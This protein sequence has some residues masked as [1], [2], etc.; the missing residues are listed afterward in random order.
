MAASISY[1]IGGKFDSKPLDQAN[2]GIQKLTK[3][4]GAMKLAIG[5]FVIGTAL[6]GLKSVVDGSTEAFTNQ[7]KALTAANKAFA[8]NNKLS[9]ESVKNIKAAMD[10]FSLNNFIDG[11]TLNNAAALASNMGLNET[12]IIKT[13]DA[14]KEL[15]A[16]TGQDLN[17]CVKQLSASYSGN[18]SQLQKLNPELKNLTKEELANGKAIELIK[19]KYDGFSESMAN[20]FEGRATQFKNQFSD[21]QASIGGIGKALSFVGQGKMLEPLKEMTSYIEEHKNQIINFFLHLP[22]IAGV[23]FNAV[24]ESLSRLFT[25]DG[26]IDLG[27]YIVTSVQNWMPVLTEIWKAIGEVMFGVFDV[28]FGNLGRLFYNKVI[29]SIKEGLQNVINDFVKEHPNIAG[30]FNLD[31]IKLDLTPKVYSKLSTYTEKASDNIEKAKHNAEEANKKQ[32]AANLAFA[33]KYSD[34]TDKATGQI[35]NILNQELP[36]DLQ[37]AFAAGGDVI[38]NK[39]ASI[40]VGASGSV[41]TSKAESGVKRLTS[42]LNQLGGVFDITGRLIT[43]FSERASAIGKAKETFSQAMEGVVEG[44]AEAAMAQQG[45]AAATQA[46]SASFKSSIIGLIIEL[47]VQFASALREVSPAMDELMNGITTIMSTIADIVGPISESILR[48]FADGLKSIGTIIGNLLLPIL[49]VLDMLFTPMFTALT[50]ILKV[51]GQIVANLQPIITLIVTLLTKLSPMN[52]ILK[53]LTG[54]LN[55]FGEAIKFIYN[56]I[57]VPVVNFLLKIITSIGNFFIK[58]YNGVVGVLNSISIFGW[59]PFNFSTKNEL[60]YESMKISE[61][62]DESST[63]ADTNEGSTTKV[64]GGSATYNAAKDVYVN[65]YFNSSYVNGDAEEIAINL[66][67]EIKRAESKNLI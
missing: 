18:I 44:T 38:A 4:A 47:I 63:T 13:L 10:G 31:Q 60:N 19:S 56:K 7:N 57:L 41:D 45:L 61:V 39:V 49:K 22:D 1:K 42:A 5:G 23:A 20:T 48:P 37:A 11:D 65:I 43:I 2:K 9:A 58:M 6:K 62:T 34:I 33:S 50:K 26:M 28:T 36:A 51:F 8:N 67:R 55:I 24:K 15:S 54:V 46:A 35:K 64:S 29:L 25:K 59:H 40:D 32:M 12:Q 3:A 17:T 21:F 53:L 66:A 27:K 14:A 30:F 52:I 16:A